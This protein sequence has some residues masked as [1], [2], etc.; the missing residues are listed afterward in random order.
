MRTYLEI[1]KQNRRLGR[2]NA[3]AASVIDEM[4][5]R[6]LTLHLEYGNGHERWG[7]SD[8]RESRS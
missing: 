7:L 8:G 6:D 5:R 4:R 1:T 2:L 3:E